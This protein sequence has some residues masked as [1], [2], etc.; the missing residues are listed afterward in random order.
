MSEFRFLERSAKQQ[1]TEFAGG[2]RFRP[3]ILRSH[4]HD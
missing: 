2:P 1:L 4:G 3:L